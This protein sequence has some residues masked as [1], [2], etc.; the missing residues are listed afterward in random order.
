MPAIIKP[1]TASAQLTQAMVKL[2]IESGLVPE[3]ALQLIC[4]G[5]GD[6]FEHL[7][8]QDAVT[9]TGSAQT[10][11]KLRSHPRL[12]QNPSPSPWKPTR[13]TVAF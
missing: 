5:V 1:A 6:I 9:F 10:G 7:D 4:G 11:Q 2:I 13:S 3:G 12:L 8:Y